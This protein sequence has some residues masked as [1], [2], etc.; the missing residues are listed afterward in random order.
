MCEEHDFIR[1]MIISLAV[2]AAFP[3][4]T[5]ANGQ[6]EK[7][8]IVIT[9]A[10][11]DA[12]KQILGEFKKHEYKVRISSDVQSYL[13]CEAHKKL[14]RYGWKVVPYLIEQADRQ[15]AVDA[16][17]GSALVKDKNVRTPEQV[18]E[19]N[20]TRKSRA[21]KT[22][23][24]F[25]LETVLRELPSGKVAPYDLNK[26]GIPYNG[27]FEWVK[28]WQHHKD[29]FVFITIHPLV[30]PPLIDEH[31]IVPQV[32]TTVK[33]GLLDIYAVDAS[34]RQIIERAAAEMNIDV[35]IGEHEY[36]EVR[37]TIRMK[38]VTF[39][40]FLY[41]AG[42]RVFME[43][44]KYSK[45]ET[46]YRIGGKTPAKPTKKISGW[47]IMM[48]NTVFN[49]GD[50]IPVTVITWETDQLVDPCDPVFHR[51]GSFQV[52]TNDSKIIKDYE[53]ITKAQP[54]IPLITISEGRY[55]FQVFLN[56]FCKLTEGEYNIQ[57]RYLD[58]ETPSVAIELYD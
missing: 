6:G 13:D 7:T 57:F 35:F 19:Y 27:V 21:A 45:T 50:E 58:N 20:R 3:L 40:E 9:Q 16:F 28:W 37:T 5:D 41:M 54:T 30:I 47:G 12:I 17:I 36:L 26:G 53:P 11:E 33:E 46:G 10:D 52:T 55:K 48:E 34:Y 18:Y 4:F 51:Y 1:N 31:S 43:G 42:R 39:E 38:S 8:T 24:P 2:I 25:I 29:K 56:K 14:L 15:E 32:R 49:V 44:F 23:A 22:L